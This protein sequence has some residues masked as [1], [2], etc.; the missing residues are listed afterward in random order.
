[1][2][3]HHF[4]TYFL[5]ALLF[6]VGMVV[7]SIFQPFL[8]SIVAAAVLAALFQGV[9]A[10]FLKTFRNHAGW[11]AMATCLAIFLIIVTPLFAVLGIAAGEAGRAYQSIGAQGGIGHFVERSVAVIRAVPHS[12]LVFS[13]QALDTNRILGDIRSASQ[14]LLGLLQAAYQGV[15]GFFIW[16]FVMFISLFYFLIDGKKAIAKVMSLSPLRDDYERLL[17][18]KFVSMSRA[19]IKGTL[20]LGII[21]GAVV[22]FM[23]TVTGIPS[24]AVWGFITVIFSVIP[25]VGSGTI[26]LPAALIMLFLGHVWQG[27]FIIAFGSIVINIVEHVLRPRLIGKDTQM[28]PLIVFF[29]TIGG[30][31]YFGL[32]GFIMGPIILALFMA[33]W[34]I[35]AVEFHDQL[36]TF[37]KGEGVSLL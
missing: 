7:F 3:L 22:W 26:W 28:H 20:V 17:I 23:F 19:T 25:F 36:E 33:L 37:N 5:L 9:Y 14:N 32:S 24:P 11:S 1:M 34:D 13:D 15:M 10:F 29:A 30:L 21:Q 8:T 4:N 18:R 2:K 35:Y 6:G 27:I 16:V 12:D 31:S